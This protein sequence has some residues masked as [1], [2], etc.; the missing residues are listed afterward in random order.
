MKKILVLY[1]SRTGNTE[2]M[3]KAIAEGAQNNGNIEV[4]LNF[5]IETEKLSTFDAIIVGHPLIIMTC[6][7]ISRSFSRKPQHKALI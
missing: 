6:L 1:Y 5:Y 2:K 7:L 4:E 3:A